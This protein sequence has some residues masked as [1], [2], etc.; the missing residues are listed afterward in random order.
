LLTRVSFVLNR[1]TQW[2]FQHKELRKD[3]TRRRRPSNADGA[4]C[5]DPST[6]LHV[7]KIIEIARTGE[8]DPIKI[9]SGLL[10]NSEWRRR[11]RRV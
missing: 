10:T 2:A 5:D 4:S 8:R 1:G 6:R 9:H 7:K 3:A 11:P